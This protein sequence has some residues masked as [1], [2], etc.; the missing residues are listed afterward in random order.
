MFDSCVLGVDPGIASLGIAAVARR[1]RRPDLLWTETVRTPADQREQHRLARIYAA[2]RAAIDAHA[3][4]ALAVERV[5][6]NR[7][8]T[9]GLQVAR[10]T[11]VVLLAAADAGIDVAEYGPLEVK[12]AITGVG[13]AS[14]RQVHAA[15]V[16]AHGLRGVPSQPDAADAVA[17]AVCHVT[18]SRLRRA[19]DR[20]VAR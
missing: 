2:V 14:K 17:V 3:A 4:A 8:V 7:N 11:G 6:W 13:N 10:A 5:A 12:L 9:S 15:L 16:S 19:A 20:A 18:Q 1:D